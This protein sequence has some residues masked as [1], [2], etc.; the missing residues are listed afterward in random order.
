MVWRSREHT[1]GEK[2]DG[3]SE[4]SLQDP[5]SCEEGAG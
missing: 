5:G 3:E 1:P 4:G 2:E